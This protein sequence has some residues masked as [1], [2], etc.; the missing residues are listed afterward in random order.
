MVQLLVS[1]WSPYKTCARPSRKGSP[2]EK[3]LF[4]ILASSAQ[5]DLMLNL[6]NLDFNKNTPRENEY[7]TFLLKSDSW[8]SPEQKGFTTALRSAT[9]TT[10]NY[11]LNIP[12]EGRSNRSFQ[13]W[14]VR[15]PVRLGGFGFRSLLDTV[16]PAFIGALEQ[17]L[18][19]WQEWHLSPT[20]WHSW[21]RRL[22]WR[23]CTW[24]R[25]VESDVE[26]W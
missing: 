21:W 25:Q 5:I 11:V 15:Q 23:G 26:L 3:R 6:F 13:D 22:L 18:F 20:G 12:V 1:E 2:Q 7:I 19:L 9:M 8:T 16:G 24:G 17:A 14:V 10:W 4:F